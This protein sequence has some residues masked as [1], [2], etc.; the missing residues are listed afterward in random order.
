VNFST[1][2]HKRTAAFSSHW[3]AVFGVLACLICHTDK[4]LP[5]IATVQHIDNVLNLTQK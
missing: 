1:W 3:L 5:E 2:R 4:Y